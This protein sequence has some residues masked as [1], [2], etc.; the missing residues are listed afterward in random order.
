QLSTGLRHALIADSTKIRNRKLINRRMIQKQVTKWD[1][2]P[3]RK[4]LSL[5]EGEL[6][7]S[8]FPLT[9]ALFGNTTLLR[10]ISQSNAR[11]LSRPGQHARVDLRRSRHV[12]LHS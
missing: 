11:T 3:V 9:Q 12:Q 6:C 4:L 7:H 2:G 5:H 10:K 1:M 8:S